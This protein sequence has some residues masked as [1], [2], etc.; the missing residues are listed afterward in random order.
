MPVSI[1]IVDDHDGF[2]R[3]A[4]RAL[5]ADGFAVIGQAAD[6]ASGLAEAARL[7]PDVVLLDIHLPDGCG[8]EFAPKFAAQ[9]PGAQVILTSTYDAHDVSHVIGEP[10]IAG[11]LPKSELSGD[12][13]AALLSPAGHGG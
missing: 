4:A 7:H 13:L 2:R 9:A 8:M 5:E 11:F 10:G 6:L 12:A 1:L 3:R